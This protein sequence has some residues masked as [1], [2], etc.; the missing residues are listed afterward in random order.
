MSDQAISI[1]ALNAAKQS[2]MVGITRTFTV[3]ANQRVANARPVT[4]SELGRRDGGF[5]SA[6]IVGAFDLLRAVGILP[7]MRSRHQTGSY[8]GANVGL[9]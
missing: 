3:L 7:P 4:G 5:V 8:G 1:A 6:D 9:A 2:E